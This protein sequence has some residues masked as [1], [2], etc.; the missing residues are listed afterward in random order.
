LIRDV[1]ILNNHILKQILFLVLLQTSVFF[2]H[3]QLP[4]RIPQS[5]EMKQMVTE[6]KKEIAGLEKEIKEAEK[7]DALA[8]AAMKKQLNTY[9][10]MLAALDKSR[11]VEAKTKSPSAAIK[12][13]LLQT[14]SPITAVFLKQPVMAPTAAQ[15][16]DRFFWYR[17]RMLNDSTLITAKRTVVQYSKKRSQLIVQP[18]EKKDSFALIVKEIIRSEQ[19]KQELVDQ[20]NNIKNGF[21]YYPYVTTS[22]AVYDDLTK[23]FSGAVNN[24]LTFNPGLPILGLQKKRE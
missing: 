6:L 14:P 18:E 23:R 22:L 20:F 1:I 9:K 7:E 11:P 2:S 21:I 3:S 10:T 12:N 19:R 5:D 13:K 17:G 16:K 24:T 4:T 8:A 15:A